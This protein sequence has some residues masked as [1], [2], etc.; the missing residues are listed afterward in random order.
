[1]SKL[2]FSLPPLSPDYSGV[3]SVFHDL[4]LLT[5]I[6]DASGCTGTY[7]GYDEPRW[8]GSSSPVFCSGLREMDAI[9][10]DDEKLLQKI[11]AA[12][13]DMAHRGGG[14]RG[15]GAR[16]GGAPGVV[17]IGSPV[18]M[19]IGF[20][21]KGFAALVENRTGLPALGFP[22][23]GLGYYDQ[24]QKDAYLALARRFLP[25]KAAKDPR[26]VNILGASALDGF[27]DA[28]L[29]ALEALLEG[30]GLRRGAIWGA[31]SSLEELKESPGA[32][33]NWVVTAAA[34]PAARY[35]QER[36]GIP[37]AAGLPAGK[38]EEERLA[39]ALTAAVRGAEP[40]AGFP[41]RRDGGTRRRTLILGEALFCASLRARLESEDPEAGIRIGT[42]FGE[43]RELLGP[44]DCFFDT[45]EEAARAL[46]D[47]ELETL[48]ADPLL[49]RLVP[50]GFAIRLVPA[51]HR[52]VSGRLCGEGRAAFFSKRLV[53]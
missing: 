46:A 6:H 22:V 21:F 13:A 28:A 2:L 8:F 34:L 9:L 1:M 17:I 12:L 52:A 5:V 39:A 41:S 32:G 31:R 30:A 50:P 53:S 43:G 35:F 4:G 40:K 49:G 29:D 27:D 10:G 11:E 16:R 48:I 44:G 7:T 45:E 38:A 15:G 37:F 33:A 47:T 36:Y 14:A 26:R 51:P 25:E 3:A 42:F 24:G 18:P 19:V 23:T 20:D